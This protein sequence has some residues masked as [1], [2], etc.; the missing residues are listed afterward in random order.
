LFS[1]VCAIRMIVLLHRGRMASAVVASE[2]AAII[3]WV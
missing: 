3:G 2:Q 1:A